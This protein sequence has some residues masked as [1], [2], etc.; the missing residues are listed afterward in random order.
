MRGVVLLFAAI[1]AV[2]ASGAAWLVATEEPADAALPGANGKIAFS[3]N[4]TTGEGV[5]NPERDFEIFTIN[6]DGTGLTQITHNSTRDV[7]PAWSPDGAKIAYVN[8]TSP[9]DTTQDGEIYTVSAEGGSPNPFTDNDLNDSDPTWSPDGKKLAFIQGRFLTVK[10]ADG[11]GREVHITSGG[12]VSSDPQSGVLPRA[13]NP[14][15]SP[16]GTKIAFRSGTCGEEI[17]V[18]DSDGTNLTQL[19]NVCYEGHYS[20][21]SPEWSPDGTR[22]AFVRINYFSG[23]SDPDIYIMDSDG[24]DQTLL[25]TYADYSFLAWSPDDARIAFNTGSAIQVMGSDGS[26]PTFLT[27][28]NH[29]SWQRLCTKGTEGADALEGTPSSDLLCGLGG[30]D[31][32]RGS[33]GYDIL[34]GGMGND[35]LIANGDGK[36]DTLTC[37][38]GNRDTARYEKGTDSVAKS[39]EIR[40]PQ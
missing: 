35:V 9:G 29:P 22:I 30:A 15:W 5:D 26:N 6:P 20:D 10:N 14:A 32:M 39:C 7:L 18:V 8:Y 17:W 11:S 1:A 40:K 37:G 33:G 27:S 36:A 31:T 24:S 25:S 4:R 34:K 19:T 2:A 28:G 23:E 21:L 16:D 3:S 12:P 13:F 38:K